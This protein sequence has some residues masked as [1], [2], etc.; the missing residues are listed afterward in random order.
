MWLRYMEEPTSLL[1]SSRPGEVAWVSGLEDLAKG[2]YQLNNWKQRLL[3]EGRDVGKLS[4]RVASHYPAQ[5]LYKFD[6]AIYVHS[7]PYRQRG[8]YAPAFLFTDPK[9]SVHQF[10][11]RCIQS[12]LDAS[13]PLEDSIDDIW[14]KYCS[15]LFSDQQV[16]KSQIVIAPKAK[17]T[18][19]SVRN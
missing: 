7:F 16:L 10:L 15:K 11:C 6:N 4:I 9:T 13:T 17:G 8:F 1:T 2:L 3:Q 12:S 5:A 19:A 18:S 14:K